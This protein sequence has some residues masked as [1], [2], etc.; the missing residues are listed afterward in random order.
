MGRILEQKHQRQDGELDGRHEE[1]LDGRHEELDERHQLLDERH[2]EELRSP[3][4]QAQESWSKP[5]LQNSIG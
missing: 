1:E 5:M 2:E 3:V 4:V